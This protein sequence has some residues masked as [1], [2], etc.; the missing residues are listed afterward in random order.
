[1]NSVETEDRDIQKNQMKPLDI[2]CNISRLRDGIWEKIVFGFGLHFPTHS[3]F[4][5]SY[6]K[7][8]SDLK[9]IWKWHHYDRRRSQ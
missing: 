9:K 4:D 1:M 5:V 3:D 2:Y 6:G 7:D 8:I